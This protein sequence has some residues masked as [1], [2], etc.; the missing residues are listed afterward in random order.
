MASARRVKLVNILV[1]LAGSGLALLAWTQ[2][3]VN[4]E[5]AQSGSARQTIEVAGATAAPGVTALA[6]AGMALAGALSI[7]GPVI[8]LVLGVLGVLLGS[9]VFL[10]A[11]LAITDPAT[12]SAGAVTDVTGIAGTESVVDAVV[13]ASLTAWPFVALLSGVVIAG[14]GVSVLVTARHWPG[15]TSR[16]QAVRFAPADPDDSGAADAA[17]QERD[18]IDDWDGLSRGE[19]PTGPR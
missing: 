2:P 3:W 1:V 7:A 12:A 13:S 8:R 19:D 15:P 4:A 5:V 6:L 11:F 17:G 9:S 10:S 14:A 18:S 16:Y